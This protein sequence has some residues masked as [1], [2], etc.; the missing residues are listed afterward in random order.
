[1]YLYIVKKIKDGLLVYVVDGLNLFRSD[2]RNVGDLIEKEIW[3]DFNK[4]LDNYILLFKKIKLI[5]W[6]YIFILYFFIYNDVG[7]VV[8]VIGIEFEVKY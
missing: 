7:K 6:G 8:G 2:F 3:G 5:F 4:V 1:M